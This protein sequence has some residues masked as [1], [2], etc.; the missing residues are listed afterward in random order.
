MSLLDFFLSPFLYFYSACE[1]GGYL[2]FPQALLPSFALF[3]RDQKAKGEAGQ[4]ATG[5]AGTAVRGA[6]EDFSCQLLVTVISQDGQDAGVKQI[7]FYPA[8]LG[9][10]EVLHS[11]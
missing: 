5:T 1:E 6:A 7:Y 4:R 10:A 2:R 9:V 8:R 11:Q 3:L